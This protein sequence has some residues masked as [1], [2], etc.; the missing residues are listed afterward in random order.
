VTYADLWPGVAL[1]YDAAAGEIPR[2]TYGVE[3]NASQESIHLRYNA[4]DSCI[5]FAVICSC[6]RLV[7]VKQIDRQRR[8]TAS[9]AAAISAAR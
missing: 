7:R 3:P 6:D 9:S 4:A 5:C 2:S 1:S 8:L